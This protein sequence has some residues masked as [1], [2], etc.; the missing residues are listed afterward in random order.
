MDGFQ[1]GAQV[2]IAH[3][4]ALTSTNSVWPELS[5]HQ[6]APQQE[7][8]C[9]LVC[10]SSAKLNS[11]HK[12]PAFGSIPWCL[13]RM[14]SAV[15]CLLSGTPS[16]QCTVLCCPNNRRPFLRY[17]LADSVDWLFAAANCTRGWLRSMLLLYSAL[18]CTRG[19]A[20]PYAATAVTAAA[21]AFCGVAPAADGP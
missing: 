14:G 9:T 4:H 11:S 20:V 10:Q 13:C 18:Y 15:N 8:F 19:Q 17:N 16:L 3:M 2:H 6:A 12:E 5:S 7:Q 1:C 21:A